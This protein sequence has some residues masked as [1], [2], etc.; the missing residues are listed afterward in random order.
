MLWYKLLTKRCRELVRES[1]GTTFKKIKMSPIY[2]PYN[3]DL[4]TYV[5][6]CRFKH[7]MRAIIPRYASL[8]D[9][10]RGYILLAFY[11]QYKLAIKLT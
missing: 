5:N 4:Y 9:F 8:G 1:K 10:C 6:F 2:I 7:A 3:S 11:G